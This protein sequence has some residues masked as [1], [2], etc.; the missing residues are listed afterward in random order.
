MQ[1]GCMEDDYRNLTAKV[2][3]NVDDRIKRYDFSK[4]SF[5][6][7]YVALSGGTLLISVMSQQYNCLMKLY[8]KFYKICIFMKMYL[9]S[10]F[11]L[12]YVRAEIKCACHYDWTWSK[13]LLISKKNQKIWKSMYKVNGELSSCDITSL[14]KFHPERATY[15][16]LHFHFSFNGLSKS[17]QTFTVGFVKYPSTQ[18]IL[19][20]CLGKLPL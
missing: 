11:V 20:C 6:F 13:G 16:T 4:V 8:T 5:Y 1:F 18:P 14:A 12:R 10:S 7:V 17:A 9:P 19:H 2:W 15:I 3:A